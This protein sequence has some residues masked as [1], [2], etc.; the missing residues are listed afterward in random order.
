MHLLQE[1]VQIGGVRVVMF[2]N[3]HAEVPEVE[4]ETEGVCI[5]FVVASHRNK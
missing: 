2:G 3:P 1:P 5:A 4:Q